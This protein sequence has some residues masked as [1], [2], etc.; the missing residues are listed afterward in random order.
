MPSN[1]AMIT[2]IIELDADA[3]TDGLNNADLAALLKKLREARE[4]EAP[5]VKTAGTTVAP[6]KSITTRRGLLDAGSPIC[7][8]DLA[9]GEAGEKSLA[10]HIRN[11]AVVE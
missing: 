7:A 5:V 6:G 2:D 8:Q 10:E 1:K 11:G 4:L 9:D 3:N